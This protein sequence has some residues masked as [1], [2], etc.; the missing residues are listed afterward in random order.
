[1]HESI[2]YLDGQFLP[3]AD[4]RISVLDRGFIFGDGIYELIPVYDG[5]AFGLAEHLSRMHLSLQSAMIADPHTEEKWRS[6]VEDLIQQNGG[7]DQ[8]IYVQVTR[9]AA[10]RSHVLE[11]HIRPTILSCPMLPR[12]TLSANR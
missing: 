5:V 8:N 4:A 6:L 1:M 11:Q 12:R 7:G 10:P 3:L 9:G 2:C